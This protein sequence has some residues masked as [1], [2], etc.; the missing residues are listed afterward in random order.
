MS[1]GIEPGQ[2]LCE[3]SRLGNPGGTTVILVLLFHDTLL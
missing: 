2:T 1:Y 3:E